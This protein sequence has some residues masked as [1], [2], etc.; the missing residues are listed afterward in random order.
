METNQVNIAGCAP[1][2]L[3]GL[4]I[5]TLKFL[6][7]CSPTF[8]T[9]NTKKSNKAHKQIAGWRGQSGSK[10]WFLE[11]DMIVAPTLS[12]SLILSGCR[13]AEQKYC[14]PRKSS[15]TQIHQNTFIAAPVFQSRLSSSCS[16]GHALEMFSLY[17]FMKFISLNRWLSWTAECLT[18]KLSC[19]GFFLFLFFSPHVSRFASRLL[20]LFLFPPPCISSSPNLCW[21]VCFHLG[22]IS[23]FPDFPP[24]VDLALLSQRLGCPFL[25]T[26]ETCQT[27]KVTKTIIHIFLWLYT[28]EIITNPNGGFHSQHCEY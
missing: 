25:A 7:F 23:V 17:V 13:I 15:C 28:N 27:T 1:L 20:S 6:W 21:F 22:V 8:V 4:G 10:D 26:V 24:G 9:P 5:T 19:F 2:I 18:Q 11:T 14:R 3:R 16:L 12:W